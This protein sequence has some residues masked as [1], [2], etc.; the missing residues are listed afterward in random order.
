MFISFSHYMLH[1]FRN[2]ITSHKFNLSGSIN[3]NGWP[4]LIQVC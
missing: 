2:H 3:I 4:R 1:T